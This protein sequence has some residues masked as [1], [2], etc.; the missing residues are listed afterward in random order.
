MVE[1]NPVMQ[2]AEIRAVRKSQKMCERVCGEDY[3][4][5]GLGLPSDPEGIMEGVEL[6]HESCILRC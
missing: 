5:L 1:S 3:I 6:A 4:C 2:L